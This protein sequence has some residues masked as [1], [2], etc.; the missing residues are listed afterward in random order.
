VYVYYT[1]E[2]HFH[3]PDSGFLSTRFLRLEMSLP[4]LP[5]STTHSL[6]QLCTLKSFQSFN[7]HLLSAPGP[8]LSATWPRVSL[9]VS[10]DSF[11][12]L[13]PYI[14][15][16]FKPTTPSHH[17]LLFQDL[18][19]TDLRQIAPVHS[20]FEGQKY[21]VRSQLERL[22]CLCCRSSWKRRRLLT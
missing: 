12:N 18:N 16:C 8:R 15:I 2:P 19:Q 13:Y 9:M 3:R 21:L 6:I 20:L 1:K 22:R 17:S 5:I 14:S 10:F 11:G 7:T 4:T